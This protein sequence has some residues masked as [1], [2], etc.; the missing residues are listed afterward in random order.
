MSLKVIC[1]KVNINGGHCLKKIE[2]LK[3]CL[4][5]CDLILVT[6]KG[7]GPNK[8]FIQHFRENYI[9]KMSWKILNIPTTMSVHFGILL[10]ACDPY[11]I[12][13]YNIIVHRYN[14][15]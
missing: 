11:C 9:S 2:Y 12:I 4:I 1:H 10:F 5:H 14:F 6:S 15:P 3:I 7:L 13:W 8:C